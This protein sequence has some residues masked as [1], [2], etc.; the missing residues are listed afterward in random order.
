MIYSEI[1]KLRLASGTV[2]C[3]LS[4]IVLV[5]LG[6]SNRGS[7][8]HAA[9]LIGVAKAAYFPKISLT[10]FLGGQSSQLSSLFDGPNRAWQFVPSTW[11]T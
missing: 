3:L 8:T 11:P 5:A 1:T 9:A 6:C 2:F 7:Q 4:F 10:G